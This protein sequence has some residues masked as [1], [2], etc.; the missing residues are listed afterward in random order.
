MGGPHFCPD[1]GAAFADTEHMLW[2]C[3]RLKRRLTAKQRWVHNSRMKA[4]GQPLAF[5]NCGLAPAAWT[6]TFDSPAARAELG[7]SLEG[8][9]DHGE[10]VWVDGGCVS[11]GVRARAGFGVFG[12]PESTHNEGKPL[13]GGLQTAQRAEVRALARV[14]QRVQRPVTVVS[15]SANTVRIMMHIMDGAV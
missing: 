15:D 11:H 12:G 6:P 1:C 2:D 3:D 8:I 13:E 9:A 7:L 14:L 4:G 5:W 10:E